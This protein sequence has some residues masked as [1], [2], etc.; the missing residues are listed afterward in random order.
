[1][2]L[3]C[4]QTALPFAVFKLLK[5]N[6]FT[7][8]RLDFGLQMQELFLSEIAATTLPANNKEQLHPKQRILFSK[9]LVWSCR[10][11]FQT[12]VIHFLP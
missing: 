8:D 3:N 5:R 9:V 12:I 7:I 4:A 2:I 1:M 11:G 6:S 10:L